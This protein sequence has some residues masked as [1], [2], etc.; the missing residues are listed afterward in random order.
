MKIKQFGIVLQNFAN[1]GFFFS[2]EILSIGQ[3]HIL[4][5]KICQNFT[6]TK[7]TLISSLIPNLLL[8]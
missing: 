4:Q 2:G 7:K 6:P 1:V 5:V 8:L 3:N